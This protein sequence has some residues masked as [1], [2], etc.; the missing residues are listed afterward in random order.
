MSKTKTQNAGMSDQFS[1][2]LDG[3][4]EA[5]LWSTIPMAPEEEDMVEPADQY[6]ISNE[7][8]TKLRGT[9]AYFIRSW[10]LDHYS[11]IEKAVETL[12]SWDRVGHDFW[13]TAEGHGAGF[14]DRG[15][16]Q[17]GDDLTDSVSGH[18]DLVGFYLNDEM[19]H[20]LIDTYN[21]TE[22]SDDLFFL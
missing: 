17:L 12:G 20:V 6:E 10:F 5:A 4:V 7:E 1:E 14:W 9:L 15:L 8:L 18:S 16:E 3:A 21:V 22:F 11:L 13:L 2:V 19:T